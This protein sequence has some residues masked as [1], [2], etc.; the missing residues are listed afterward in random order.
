V[1]FVYQ[2]EPEVAAEWF[3]PLG[4]GARAV[5]DLPKR[6][7]DAFEVERGGLK[8]MFGPG[9]IRCGLRATRKGHRIGRKV[10]DPWTLPLLVAVREGA[11]VWEH[12]GRFAG[13]GPDPAAIPTLIEQ[14]SP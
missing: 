12:R 5:A 11:V 13:D 14:E 4:H 7:Y 8:E 2:G 6:L 9:A 10:G 1:V 3:G